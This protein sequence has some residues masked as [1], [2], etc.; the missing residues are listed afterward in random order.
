[1]S[2]DEQFGDVLDEEEED[3]RDLLP[4]DDD[5]DPN[6]SYWATWKGSLLVGALQDQ[7][8]SYFADA[9]ARGLLTM[10]II[11]Y[12]AHHGLTPDDLREF[13]TQQI[14]FTGNEMEL[15]R[16]HINVVRGYVRQQTT[17]ALGDR[18]A[19]KAVVANEDHQSWAKSELAD[20]IVN[21]LYKRYAAPCDPKVAES[22]GVFG[23]GA[24]HTRWDFHGGDDVKVMEDIDVGDGT[25]AQKPKKVKSGAPVTSVVYPWSLVQE[26]KA[27]AEAMWYLVREPDNKWNLIAQ[28]PDKKEDILNVS[29]APDEYD[30]RRLFRL[31][32]LDTSNNDRI[33]V[34]HFYHAA[35]AAIPT[36]RYCIVYGDV[37][38][39]DGPCPTRNKMP[40]SVI[41]SG[42]FL[43]TTFGYADAW[44][45]LA[46]QQALNQL[47][48]DEMQNYALFGRQSIAIE[49]G[50]KVTADALAKGAA[51]YTPPGAKMPQAIQL[52]AIPPTLGTLKDYLHKMLDL[53]S[54]QNAASR[55]DPDPNVRSGEMNA[56][57]DSISLRYQSFRQEGVR[58]Y[59][60][61]NAEIYL[62]LID[63]YGTTP[64]LVELVGIDNRT[65]LAEYTADDLSAVQRITID[66]VPPA[67]QSSAFRLQLYQQLQALPQNE[68]AG[69]YEMVVNGNNSQFMKL[70]RSSEMYIKRENERLVTGQAEVVVSSNDDPFQHMPEHKALRERIMSSD[71]PDVEALKRIDDHMVQHGQVYLD[72][73]PLQCA[74]LG[75]Q[76]P[77]TIMPTPQNPMGNSA[78]QFSVATGGM[79]PPGAPAAN[80]NG[81]SGSAS[82]GKA[83]PSGESSSGAAQRSDQNGTKE[84]HPSGTPLPSPSTPP[85]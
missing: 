63:R 70:D 2:P 8:N 9:R 44:D 54:G 40:V 71:N 50:T 39:W 41:R 10:W 65:F 68:R 20:G 53:V 81:G 58:N 66:A 42:E 13:A 61:R 46:I 60:I 36:G 77:P 3:P 75:I 82:A 7:E 51:F 14:G 67:M 24:S 84:M 37:I 72:M 79:Q 73:S 59:R 43:E 29:D 30:F 17:L 27:A 76:P 52:T 74:M 38:V 85:S 6:A 18:A 22:D 35:C 16:F 26:T 5:G 47:N 32:D 28:H 11:A 15:L 57:L 62:D 1:M 23:S 31:D 45:M 80:S 12:A 48:S 69:A 78:Y 4:A 49:Q 34:K 55:G 64:F 83:L 25:T 19:F 21:G 33:V 56:L